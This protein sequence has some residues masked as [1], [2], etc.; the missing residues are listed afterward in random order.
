VE[1]AQRK[2]ERSRLQETDPVVF[3]RRPL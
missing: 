3:F 1:Y 2:K